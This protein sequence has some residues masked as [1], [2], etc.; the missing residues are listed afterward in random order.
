M[1]NN[2]Q[3]NIKQF[4]QLAH[5]FQVK[6]LMVGGGAVNFHGYQRHSADV[7]FWI[8]TSEENLKQLVLVFKEMGYEIENFPEEVRK[9]EQNISV[10]F[11]PADLDLELI[12]RFSLSKSFDEAYRDAEIV[13]INDIEVFKW[14]VLS[15]D[16][17]IESKQ[18]A[19]RPKDLLDIQQLQKNNGTQK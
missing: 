19:S 17:L 3:N 14:Y 6:M 13:T 16:D 9:G 7:D 8:E 5:H 12:T 4:L 2:W 11:S 10:K 15:F 18:R 1:I